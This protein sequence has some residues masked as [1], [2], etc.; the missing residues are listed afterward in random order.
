MDS[1][2]TCKRNCVYRNESTAWGCSLYGCKYIEMT[3]ESRVKTI[4][5][6]LNIT[7][8]NKRAKELLKSENCPLFKEKK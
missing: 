1:S 5:K 6:K 4:Y 3:G 7:H 2:G 8:M